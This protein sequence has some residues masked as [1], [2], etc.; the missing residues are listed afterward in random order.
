MKVA[1][2]RELQ[3]LQRHYVSSVIFK[4]FSLLRLPVYTCNDWWL[5][6]LLLKTSW[7]DMFLISLAQ[8]NVTVD[9][10]QALGLVDAA[11]G[12][13]PWMTSAD[14]TTI[15]SHASQVNDLLQRLRHM[16]LD[17]TE[18][19]CLKALVL[20]RSGDNARLM[21]VDIMAPNVSKS[22]TQLVRYTPITKTAKTYRM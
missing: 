3:M 4:S 18:Y 2:F 20:F 22:K 8:S 5:Q 13:R 1:W 12:G 15:S 7:R 14:L 17:V 11:A 16:K 9:W 19:T 10:S 6:M 21:G